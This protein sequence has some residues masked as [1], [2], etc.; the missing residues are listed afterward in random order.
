MEFAFATQQERPDL[1]GLLAIL[2]SQFITMDFGPEGYVAD[3]S[4]VEGYEIAI[5]GY[6]KVKLP[7]DWPNG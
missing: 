4:S 1:R 2:A 6:F 3:S 5:G 7:D